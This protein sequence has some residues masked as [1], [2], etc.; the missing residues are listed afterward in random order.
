MLND[1]HR[2]E[3]EDRLRHE[4]DRAMEALD[5]FDRSRAS[6]LEETGELTMYRL[7]PADIGTEA[8][9]QE[10]QYLLASTEG[11]RLNSIDDAL[12]RLYSEPDRFGVCQNCGRE[13]DIERLRLVP[14]ATY[15]RDCQEGSERLQQ[16]G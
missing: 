14:Y 5:E 4:R 11:R 8:M 10:K 6:L 3:L 2:R 7:H 12:R 15:C 9:E 1:D 13:I 16:P